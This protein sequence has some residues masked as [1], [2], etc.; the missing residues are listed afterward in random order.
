METCIYLEPGYFKDDPS[1][2]IGTEDEND[3]SMLIRA[4]GEAWD[5]CRTCWYLY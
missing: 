2:L 5:A 3:I 1:L 4:T